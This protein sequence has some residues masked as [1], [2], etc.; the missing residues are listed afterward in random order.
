MWELVVRGVQ[1]V[2]GV[3]GWDQKQRGKLS[4]GRTPIMPSRNWLKYANRTSG[5][6][7]GSGYWK[8]WGEEFGSR[9]LA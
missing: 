4:G 5:P 3:C 1:V 6:A 7:E 9:E 2:E 8:G